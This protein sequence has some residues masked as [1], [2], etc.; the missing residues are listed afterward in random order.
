MGSKTDR[1]GF[2]WVPKQTGTDFSSDRNE[3]QW[4]P[5]K[6]GWGTIGTILI[7]LCMY[8]LAPGITTYRN[9]PEQ[10]KTDRNGPKRTHENTETDFYGY[11]N[12]PERI[13]DFSGYRNGPEQTS[14]HIE[15]NF[16]MVEKVEWGTIRTILIRY[17]PTYPR[18]H[19]PSNQ[20]SIYLTVTYLPSY[21][22]TY[23]NKPTY[24]PTFLPIPICLF[25][26]LLYSPLLSFITLHHLTY[27]TT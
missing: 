21:L 25:F 22:P 4:E 7:K 13:A 3:L 18:T 2:Q 14:A 5:E 9:G 11:R 15:T 23:K 6:V 16:N 17:L 19:P 27:L 20:S 1:N 8:W 12:G 26:N 24:L 10:I